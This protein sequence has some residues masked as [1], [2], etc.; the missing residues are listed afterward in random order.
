MSGVSFHHVR[1]A[2]IIAI[3]SAQISRWPLDI[4]FRGTLQFICTYIIPRLK[5]MH[6]PI[7]SPRLRFNGQVMNQGKR[8][9][10]KS[11]TML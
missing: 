10:M 2:V 5:V 9:N 11:M 8:A 6:S 3:L 4:A 7:F 1:I